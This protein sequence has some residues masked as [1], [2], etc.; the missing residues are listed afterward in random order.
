MGKSWEGLVIEDLLCGLSGRGIAFYTERIL[1][2]PFA[3]LG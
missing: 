2:V 1:G 3:C